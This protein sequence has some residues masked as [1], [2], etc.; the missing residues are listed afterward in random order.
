MDAERRKKWLI[1]VTL[2]CVGVWLADNMVFT[3]LLTLWDKR[4]VRIATI[5]QDLAKNTSLMDRKSDLKARWDDMKKRALPARASDA[6]KAVLESVNQWIGDSKLTVTAL[7]PH[8]TRPNKEA[9]VFEVQLDGKGDMESA[10]RFIYALE[11]GNLPL[12]VENLELISQNE[13]GKE[14]NISLRFSGL[15][16]EE[17]SQ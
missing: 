14:L 12:R 1:I 6:E 13:K 10:S 4:T 2:L 7:K 8:W 3:P 17:T 16:L 15:V 9:Q 11:T 5:E